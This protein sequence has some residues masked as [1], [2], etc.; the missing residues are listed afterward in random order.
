MSRF[1]TGELRQ[2]FEAAI[3]RLVR[4]TVAVPAEHNSN[5]LLAGTARQRVVGISRTGMS[6]FSVL[7]YTKRGARRRAGGRHP[8]ER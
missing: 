2:Q 7:G 6:S 5:A 8:V 4:H 3:F 1:L